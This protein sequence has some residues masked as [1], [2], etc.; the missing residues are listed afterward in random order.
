MFIACLSCIFVILL[1]KF[2]SYHIIDSDSQSNHVHTIIV[3]ESFPIIY[4]LT[5][6]CTDPHVNSSENWDNS[7]ILS[8]HVRSYVRI[9]IKTVYM[10]QCCP[11][12]RTVNDQCHEC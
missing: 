11:N 9:G 6:P 1:N 5:K 12:N 10:A 7:Q 2:I 3:N 8:S 4:E